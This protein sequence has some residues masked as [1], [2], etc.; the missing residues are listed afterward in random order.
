[1]DGSPMPDGPDMT[2]GEFAINAFRFVCVIGI[3]LLLI[4]AWP[5][6]AAWRPYQKIAR[7][8]Q[9]TWNAFDKPPVFSTDRRKFTLQKLWVLAKFLPFIGCLIYG[10]WLLGPAC[11]WWF[12]GCWTLAGAYVII[13]VVYEIC[14]GPEALR[15]AYRKQIARAV[16]R[17]GLSEALGVDD[18]E[19]NDA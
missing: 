18:Q 8:W 7:V 11:F 5:F 15:K 10:S 17:S 4:W 13:L 3:F 9:K 16:G 2:I 6:I 14:M 19:H 12:G 1:M